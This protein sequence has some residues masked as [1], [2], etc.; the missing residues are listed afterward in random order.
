MSQP[1]VRWIEPPI[2]QASPGLLNLVNGDTFLASLLE[3][4]GFASAEEAGKFLDPRESAFEQVFSFPGMESAL[5]RIRRAIRLHQKIGVWG[6]FDVDGQ[7][8]TAVLIGTLRACGADAEYH[9]PVRGPESHGISLPFLTSFLS[10][11]IDLLITC[12]TGISA[13]EA[14]EYCR[15]KHVDLIITDHHALPEVLPEALSVINPHL[16]PEGHPFSSLAGV[17]TAYQL[18]RAIL[19]EFHPALLP[20]DLLD[21]VCLGTLADVADLSGENRFLSKSGLD[22]LRG[23][24]RMAIRSLLNNANCAQSTLNE[25]HIGFLLAPRLNAVG[26]LADAN[27][28]VEFL[29]STDAQF[30]NTFA[31]QLEGLN[32]RRRIL[33]QE[34]T[35]AVLKQLEENPAL[36]SEPVLV[37]AHPDWPGGVLGLAAGRLVEKYQKPAIVLRA[38]E[39]GIAQGSARS[40]EGVDITNA[41]SQCRDLLLG[42]GGHPMAAGL[43]LRSE[44][45]PAFRK[46]IGKVVE[47]AAPVEKVEPTLEIDT[48]LQFF[49][50]DQNLVESM[51]RLAPFGPGNPSA[52]LAS[53]DIEILETKRI[54]KNNEHTKIMVRDPAGEVREVLH[55]QSGDFEYPRGKCDLA[56]TVKSSNYRGTPQI[57][58]EWVGFKQEAGSAVLQPPKPSLQ[59]MDRRTDAA[60]EEEILALSQKPGV[61]VFREGPMIPRIPQGIDRR[62]AKNTT[63]LVIASIPPSWEVLDT[64]IQNTSPERI[65]VYGKGQVEESIIALIQRVAGLVKYAL[66]TKD[67][68]TSLSE[69]AIQCAQ[70][71][72][73]LML[74]LEFL[75]AKGMISVAFGEG[76]NLF[77]TEKGHSSEAARLQQIENALVQVV[78]ETRAFRRYFLSVDLD[79][80]LAA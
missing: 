52:I 78:E 57:T 24:N 51:E 55:W 23:T 35:N 36:L 43:S 63:D 71:E 14:A 48:F 40:V 15:R 19:E 32:G 16:L 61:S 3:R 67:G 65:V 75:D 33:M 4:R 10:Q 1:P 49:Q 13:N 54:G 72:S 11:G 59:I 30:V 80:I 12:D 58:L 47:A 26:R 2:V 29:L 68:K 31:L 25:D 66:R 74:C 41:I 76:G 7:T 5:E 50:I 18:A 46:R 64:L 6:D 8:S 34:V 53:K 73:V 56:F 44:N 38:M 79:P 27:P 39:D 9:V 60:P 69:L 22:C 17:G 37:V 20:G 21:L 28:V 70:T 42:F 62:S 45:L 77:V